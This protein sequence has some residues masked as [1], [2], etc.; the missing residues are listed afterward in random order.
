MEVRGVWCGFLLDGWIFNEH[1]IDVSGND[2]AD[3][4]E[5]SIIL[6]G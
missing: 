6:N 2:W 5:S 3:D 4:Y 1:K